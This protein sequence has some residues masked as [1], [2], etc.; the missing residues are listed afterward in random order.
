MNCKLGL[1]RKCDLI[2]LKKKA[3]RRRLWFNVLN[4]MERGLIDSVVK[5]VDRVRS[6]L[7]AKVLMCIVQKLLLALESKVKR[8]MREVG[9]PLA[10]KISLIAKSW[11]NESASAWIEDDGWILYLTVM[12]ISAA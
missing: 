5:I 10:K 2:V 9:R 12:E 7:L 3:L 4:R 8:M 11:G 1:F 6:A